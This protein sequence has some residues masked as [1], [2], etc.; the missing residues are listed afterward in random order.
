MAKRTLPNWPGRRRLPGFGKATR[1]GIVPVVVSTS[2]PEDVRRPHVGI[3]RAVGQDQPEVRQ[4]RRPR[5]VRGPPAQVFLLAQRELHVDRIHLRHRGQH[6]GGA[7]EI[8][9]V[10]LLDAR[11]PVDRGEDLGPPEVELRLVERGLGLGDARVRR[12]HVG[13]GLL[14]RGLRGGDVGLGL[15][16]VCPRRVDGGQVGEVV[17]DG[18]V[19]LLL[20]HGSA[21]G[22]RRVAVHLE[23]RL[24][25]GRHRAREVALRLRHPRLRLLDLRLRLRDLGRRLGELRLRLRE[26]ARGL[27]ERVL[28]GPR[29]DLEQEVAGLDEA[30]LGVVLAD[31]IPRDARA[32]LRRHVAHGGADPFAV[33]RHVALDDRRDDDGD[34]RRGSRRLA[35]PASPGQRCDGGGDEQDPGAPG[36]QAGRGDS[37]RSP[38]RFHRHILTRRPRHGQGMRRPS[39][40]ARTIEAPGPG[41]DL[42]RGDPRD[43]ERETTGAVLAMLGYGVC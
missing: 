22:E 37:A 30:A 42:V 26:L 25:L 11:D 4:P 34:A 32:D 39:D 6:R 17:L 8:A 31:E 1:T 5:G 15:L 33:D 28:V 23:L 38:G 14:H 41:N 40:T 10:D 20:A 3:R 7:H 36:E 21:R 9:D 24:L 12:L 35:V 29:V 27:V 13:L 2:R 43:D 18:V 19:E 16:E